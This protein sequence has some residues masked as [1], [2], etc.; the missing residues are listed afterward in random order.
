MI[1]AVN[2][3]LNKETQPEGYET[4]MFSILNQLAEK[5]PQHKFI[6]IFDH[7]Y[8]DSY[9]F[10]KNVTPIEGCFDGFYIDTNRIVAVDPFREEDFC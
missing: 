2:T 10:A 7:P 9:V 4:F 5:F 6:Y 8:S 1:I 3:R